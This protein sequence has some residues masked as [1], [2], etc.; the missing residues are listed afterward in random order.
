MKFLVFLLLASCGQPFNHAHVLSIPQEFAPY[1][2]SFLLEARNRG[3]NLYVDDLEITFHA[4]PDPTVG[5]CTKGSATPV[6]VID[7]TAW[8]SFTTS[9][10]EEL[11]FHEL[12]HCL[13]NRDHIDG[14]VTLGGVTI[15]S[16]VMSTYDFPGEIYYAYRDY[17]LNELFKP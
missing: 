15:P 16:S 1:Y 2:E 12:G 17:Y 9:D 6:V 10:R 13:L 14:T 7:P 4:L 5:R 3:V 11:I 8:Q